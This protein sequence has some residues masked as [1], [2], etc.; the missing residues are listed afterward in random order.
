M[1]SWFG[2]LNLFTP[3]E[4][5][6]FSNGIPMWCQ[7]LPPDTPYPVHL[8]PNRKQIFAD[9]QDSLIGEAFCL[10]VEQDAPPVSIGSR[11]PDKFAICILI[12]SF[13]IELCEEQA[14][15]AGLRKYANRYGFSS[16]YAYR[17]CRCS[18]NRRDHL[19]LSQ[20]HKGNQG[21]SDVRWIDNTIPVGICCRVF[22]S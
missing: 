12:F 2:H 3:L 10:T 4:I 5:R 20:V 18:R 15:R 1:V 8:R 16:D 14:T 22:E 21:T 19:L 9:Y 6:D 11:I 17:Y 13:F 7:E